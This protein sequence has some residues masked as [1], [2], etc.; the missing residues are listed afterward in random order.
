MTTTY[1]VRVFQSGRDDDVDRIR[2]AVAAE[3]VAVGL[4]RSVTVAVAEALLPDDSPAVGV[5]LGGPAAVANAALRDPVAE[6][7]ASGMVIIPIVGDLSNFHAEV[8]DYLAFANGVEWSAPEDLEPIVRLILE[9]LGIEEK[10]RRVF[11][12]HKR[13]DGLGAAEQLHDTLSHHRF[14]PFIDRFAVRAGAGVQDEIANALEE[15]AFLLLLET[16]LAHTSDWVFDEVDYALS[17]A[18]GIIIVKWPGEPIP[19]PGS[20]GLPR[21]ELDAGEITTDDHGYETLTDAG[22]NR[23]VAEVE[24]AHGRGLVR[25][26]RLIIR[27]IE[28]AAVVAGAQ[29]CTPLCQ[30]R[31]HVEHPTGSTVVGSTPR[32]PTA[33]DLQALDEAAG[34]DPSNPARVLVHS[35]RMLRPAL[36]EH[37]GWVTGSRNITVMP[38]NAIGRWW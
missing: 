31:L 33:Q 24:A 7:L 4:H 13:D 25:R 36:R 19:V 23:V 35:A 1:G 18:M 34:A 15:H 6:C 28:E 32:L 2:Q 21:L 10:H 30:W 12:S 26:R 11:I 29:S 14:R 38:E 5:F 17:H 22:L 9:E 20:H 8:P 27:S 37:L 3:L 16:P